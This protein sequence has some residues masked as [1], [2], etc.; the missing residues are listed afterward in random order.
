[1]EIF[2]RAASAKCYRYR[3][4]KS[5]FELPAGVPRILVAEKEA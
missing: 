2:K 4:S 3:E 1:V 5:I